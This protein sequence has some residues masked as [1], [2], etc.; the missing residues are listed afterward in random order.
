[1][2]EIA[3]RLPVSGFPEARFT[4][5]YLYAGGS[6]SLAGVAVVEAATRAALEAGVAARLPGSDSVVRL[7]LVPEPDGPSVRVDV[8]GRPAPLASSVW[9]PPTRSAWIHASLA[10]AASAAGFAASWFYL[11]KADMLADEWAR[12]MGHHTAGW[13]LLLT[14][15]LFP[16]S[17]WG[18]RAGIRAVQAISLV[19]FLIHAGIALANGNLD[20][21]R[22]AIWNALSGVFFLASVVYGN[23]AHRDMDPA[24][25]FE[26]GALSR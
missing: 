23:T 5:D 19:F 11:L 20:D 12:K 3:F 25:A 13:H 21:L 9:A 2:H 26:R 14:L 1:M 22:I 6:L 24:L 7:Q 4:S 16:A 15:T 17:V 18:Q 10:L 8:D